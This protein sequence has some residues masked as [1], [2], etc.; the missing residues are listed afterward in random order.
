M[1]NVVALSPYNAD[2]T[3]MQTR[4]REAVVI[5]D[6]DPTWPAL[7]RSLAGDLRAALGPVAIRIDHIGSTSV[8][9]L[10]AKPII[11]V[12]VSVAELQ[13]EAPFQIPLERLNF[14]FRADNPDLTKR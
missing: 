11:D 2:M 6:Y 8:P 7:F 4:V 1:R 3:S 14:H 5:T 10:A 12:Q 9:G 13:P